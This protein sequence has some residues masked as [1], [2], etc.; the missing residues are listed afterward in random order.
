M[1]PEYKRQRLID[2]LQWLK[3]E[4]ALIDDRKAACT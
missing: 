1:V 3:D 4:L 2:K